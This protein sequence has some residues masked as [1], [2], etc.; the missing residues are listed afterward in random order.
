MTSLT[1]HDVTVQL[2]PEERTGKKVA[3]KGKKV[4]DTVANIQDNTS[5]AIEPTDSGDETMKNTILSYFRENTVSGRMIALLV[6]GKPRTVKQIAAVAKPKSE[7]NILAPGG[8]YSQLRRLGRETGLFLLEKTADGKI[9]MRTGK[10]V[11]A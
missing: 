4:L 2:D 7:A 8:W 10:A 1:L 5:S 9:V 6:D 3:A 11:K